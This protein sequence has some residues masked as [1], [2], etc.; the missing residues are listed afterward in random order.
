[1][2]S[3]K[4]LGGGGDKDVEKMV[5]TAS[6]V[7]VDLIEMIWLPKN[8]LPYFA[9][10]EVI[11]YKVPIINR[12]SN[13]FDDVQANGWIDGTLKFYPDATGRCWGYVYDTDENRELIAS[14]L[15]NNWF[16]VID[17]R[18][19]EEIYKLAE[20]RGWETDAMT[21]SQF[22]VKKSKREKEAELHIKALEKK[23]EEFKRKEEL[24]KK[25]LDITKGEKV[26]YTD[27]RLKGVKID[28]DKREELTNKEE[29][30]GE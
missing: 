3:F 27:K 1:M 17:K 19:K 16:R 20:E 25:E 13:I 14:S 6:I 21:E 22:L 2:I 29:N 7:G 24:A 10:A 28:K 18:V 26:A 12:N 4:K 30:T 23:I 5:E 15:T 9:V 8:G 11:G